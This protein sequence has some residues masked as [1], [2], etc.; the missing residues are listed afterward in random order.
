[1]A[2]G[3]VKEHNDRKEIAETPFFQ[4][5]YGVL[6]YSSFVARRTGGRILEEKMINVSVISEISACFVYF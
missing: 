3:G 2:S 1:M 4:Y 6:L 5:A